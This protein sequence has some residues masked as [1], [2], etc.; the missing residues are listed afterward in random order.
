MKVIRVDLPPELHEYLTTVIKRYSSAGIDPEEGMILF[1]LWDFVAKRAQ[2]IELDMP[3]ATTAP[4]PQP[5]VQV[6]NPPADED[7]L[8]DR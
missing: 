1:H 2:V 8:G 6:P 4:T 5:P 7:D 3:K